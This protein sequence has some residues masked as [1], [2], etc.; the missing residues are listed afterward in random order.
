MP[1]KIEITRGRWNTVGL[2]L[3][4]RPQAGLSA[5][6]AATVRRSDRTSHK[7]GA[8]ARLLKEVIRSDLLHNSP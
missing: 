2:L 5:S 1:W 8:V 7:Y 4:Q 6:I 3:S